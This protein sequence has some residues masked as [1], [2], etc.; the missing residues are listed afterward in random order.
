MK[1][2]KQ[3]S[4]LQHDAV[5]AGRNPRLQPPRGTPDAIALVW[6]QTVDSLPAE[7][8]AAEQTPLLLTYCRH[9]ARSNLI[10]AALCGLDPLQDLDQFDRLTKLAAGESAKILAHGRALRLTVQ[11]RLKAETAHAH[12]SAAAWASGASRRPWESHLSAEDLELLA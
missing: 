9:V 1:I 4:R 6:S 12:G 3:P 7:W 5:A 2:Y 11:S 8:F 10:E